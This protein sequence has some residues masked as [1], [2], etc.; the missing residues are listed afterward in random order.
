MRKITKRKGYEPDSLIAWKR[1]YP[2]G[3]Y[4]DLTETERQDIRSECTQEQFYLCAYCC[5]PISGDRDDTMNEHVVARRLAPNRSLDFCNIVASCKTLKQCDNAH[6]SQPLPLTP[7]RGECET[8]LKFSLS[9]KVSGLTLRAQETIAVLNLGDK[10]QNNRSLIEQRKQLVQSLLLTNGIDPDAG[11][12]DDELI[13]MV[14]DDLT[15]PIDGKLEAFSPVA[16]NVLRQ[17]MA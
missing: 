2:N 11:L 10:I 6:G 1:R 13:Q 17:W 5:K 4:L 7:L 14:I 3:G 12:E 8:E 16:I 15:Q 9:G